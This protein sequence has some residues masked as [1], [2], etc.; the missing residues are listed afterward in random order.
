M[1]PLW[2]FLE[3]DPDNII[4]GLFTEK[5]E[6]V[7]D[8]VAIR[9]FL[10]EIEEAM[11]VSEEKSYAVIYEHQNALYNIAQVDYSVSFQSPNLNALQPPP[12]SSLSSSNQ[13]SDVHLSTYVASLLSRGF[14]LYWTR[15]DFNASLK[16]GF[17]DVESY[18]EREKN[19]LTSLIAVQS[20]GIKSYDMDGGASCLPL[21]LNTGKTNTDKKKK[22]LLNRIFFGSSRIAKVRTKDNLHLNTRTSSSVPPPI[23]PLPNS[24][25]FPLHIFH[26][27]L[28]ALD[29]DERMTIPLVVLDVGRFC[30][31]VHSYC[32][33]PIHEER[34]SRYLN[35]N[36]TSSF[37][38]TSPAFFLPQVPNDLQP[39]EAFAKM[40][41]SLLTLFLPWGI[42]PENDEYMFRFLGLPGVPVYVIISEL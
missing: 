23:V 39:G 3:F 10:Q 24:P 17:D 5:G 6:T 12:F 26:I 7:F 25:D 8:N 35:Q 15:K 30:E 21:L 20:L 11:K 33:S 13:K 19:F 16:E 41:L 1:E 27:S 28:P 22:G 18:S 42:S 14:E 40:F 4:N 31:S 9:K 36:Q 2:M 34:F 32:M 37:P 38:N 29:P